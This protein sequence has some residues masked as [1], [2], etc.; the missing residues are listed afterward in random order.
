MMQCSPFHEEIRG[1]PQTAIPP[2]PLPFSNQKHGWKIIRDLY[3]RNG[4]RVVA[5]EGDCNWNQSNLF[6]TVVRR[7]RRRRRRCHCRRR[8]CFVVC[9]F[10]PTKTAREFKRFR[11]VGE[12]GYLVS[13]PGPGT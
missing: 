2:S 9:W 1:D 5:Q 6:G 7:R 3:A 10:V 12:G 11:L 13:K 4:R 8:R